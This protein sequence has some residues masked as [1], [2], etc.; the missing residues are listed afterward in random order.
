METLREREKRLQDIG[1]V[2]R[3]EGAVIRKYNAMH[4]E[5][6]LSSWLRED[7][8]GEEERIKKED[9]KIGE[10]VKRKRKRAKEEKR[11]CWRILVIC[12]TVILG[13][14]WMGL[15]C[16]LWLMCVFPLLRW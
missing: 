8:V 14:R 7:L 5:N 16:L 4:E 3:E 13:L 10:E 1:A 6:F 9:K 15:W 2:P 11:T 12:W